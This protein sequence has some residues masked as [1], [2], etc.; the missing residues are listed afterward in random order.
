MNSP[1]L[2]LLVL[3][4]WLGVVMLAHG[5]N[6]TRSI[7]GTASWFASKG[8][9]QARLN[10]QA[11]AFGEVI[12]GL[13]LVFGLATPFAAAG[14]VATMTVAF[15]SIHRF[16]GFFVFARPDEGWEY[17][18]TLAV[19]ALALAILGPGS[20][21]LDNALGLVAMPA[22]WAGLGVGLTGV[23]AG[24]VQLAVFWRPPGG[25]RT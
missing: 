11:S 17:V 6:H 10:A 24:V 7:D 2:A 1:D 12:I 13:G 21:S 22:G 25:E 8:F 3:R 16:A 14:L 18:A 5:I 15:G 4:S 23:A 20:W 9:N 19:A